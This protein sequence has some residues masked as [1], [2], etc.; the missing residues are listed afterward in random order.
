YQRV[1][2]KFVGILAGY[3]IDNPT[4]HC[5]KKWGGYKTYKKFTHPLSKK[6]SPPP[7]ASFQNGDRMFP[8]F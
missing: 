2:K 7:I 3:S 6:L 8:S 1:C 5:R 4:W